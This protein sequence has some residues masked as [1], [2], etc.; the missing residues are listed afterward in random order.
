MR[1]IGRSRVG[2]GARARRPGR[3]AGSL[4]RFLLFGLKVG[5]GLLLGVACVLWARTGLQHLRRLS[6]FAITKVA[7]RGNA[8]VGTA[9]IVASLS[10]RPG[11]SILEPDLA[12]LRRRL[13]VNP[14][15]REARVTRRLPPALEVT[16][17]ERTPE[18]LLVAERS[19]LA[20]GDGV[21]L[22]EAAGAA[23][24]A[25]PR[26][27]LSGGRYAPGDRAPG[28]TVPR[29][30]ALWRTLA[31]SPAMRGERLQEIRP[32]RGGS[33]TVQTERGVLLRVRGEDAER[34]L[35]RLAAAIRHAGT[36]LQAYEAVD[37]RF[38]DRIV[39]RA[40]AQK[41]G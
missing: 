21:I 3:R 30:L 28:E 27:V 9:E 4:P 7:V 5:V 35:N 29:A 23:P 32:E 25:L 16:V 36:S 20:A 2:G 13:L 19:Y 1:G 8:Q 33:F 6:Y 10:L 15:I 12:E 17:W 41:G 40:G 14:W 34:Q 18:V 22:A 26:V 24:A 39:L 31:A 38:G 11:T 37:L